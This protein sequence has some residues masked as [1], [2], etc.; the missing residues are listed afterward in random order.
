VMPGRQNLSCPATIGAGV[1]TIWEMSK[2]GGLNLKEC[3]QPRKTLRGK[4]VFAGEAGSR[5]RPLWLW[6]RPMTSGKKQAGAPEGTARVGEQASGERFAEI[7]SGRSQRQPGR[8]ATGQ[9]S[10]GEAEA[11]GEERRGDGRMSR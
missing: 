2:L 4:I 10:P 8:E 3:L 7:T 9:D 6:G 5:L 11:E 1:G